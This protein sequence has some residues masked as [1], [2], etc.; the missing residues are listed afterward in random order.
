VHE[1]MKN[2]NLEVA[3]DGT[4]L[5]L[6]DAVT[7]SVEWR[8]TSAYHSKSIIAAYHSKSVTA[9]YHSK[10]VATAEYSKSVMAATHSN[11]DAVV[12]NSYSVAAATSCADNS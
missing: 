8:R 2:L 11:Y 3:P 5:T 4:T 7:R 1:S 12:E 6:R 10:S 9:T